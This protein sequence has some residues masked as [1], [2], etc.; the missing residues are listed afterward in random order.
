MKS[1]KTMVAFVRPQ[2]KS[3]FCRSVSLCEQ[4]ECAKLLRTWFCLICRAKAWCGKE[5][6]L[7][8]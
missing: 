7:L 5:A 1:G 8:T 2:G 4:S 3:K 6:F